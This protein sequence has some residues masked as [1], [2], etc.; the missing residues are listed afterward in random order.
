[1]AQ[2]VTIT[3]KVAY[4]ETSV[5]KENLELLLHEEIDSAIARGLLSPTMEEIVEEFDVNVSFHGE[6]K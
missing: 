3:V 4:D 6:T 5:S 1:M 2:H